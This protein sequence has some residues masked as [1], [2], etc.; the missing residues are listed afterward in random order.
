MELDSFDLPIIEC[1]GNEKDIQVK[2]TKM[3]VQ[4]KILKQNYD[5]VKNGISLYTNNKPIVL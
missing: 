1:S 3:I 5:T 4:L 2:E